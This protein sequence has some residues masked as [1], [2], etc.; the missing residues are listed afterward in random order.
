MNNKEVTVEYLLDN[1][2]EI[3]FAYQPIFRISDNSIYGYEAL[4][5]PQPFTPVEFIKAVAGMDRLFQIEEITNYYGTKHFMEA[6]LEGKLFMN[7]FPSVCMRIE[8]TKQVA[9]LGGEKMKNR[10]VYEMLEYTKLEKYAWEMKKVAFNIE[11]ATPMIAIDDFGTGS[12][13]DKEC[14]DFYRPD[15]VKIDR[16]FVSGVDKDFNKQ[17]I[18]KE[19]I[20]ELRARDII[21]LAEGIE[22]QGELNFFKSMKIDLAQG[23]FLGEPKIY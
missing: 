9:A 20:E 6:G 19:I 2:Q 3:K 13:I 18:V 5:R 12:N 15:L 14:L 11:G 22:T 1:P 4:M 23:Y 17:H 16:K 8:Q 21:I 7:S 10:L